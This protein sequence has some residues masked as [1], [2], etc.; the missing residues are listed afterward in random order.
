MTLDEFADLTRRVIAED[1]FDDYA[2][3]AVYP[4]RSFLQV[5]SGVPATEDIEKVALE[6]ATRDARNGE[7]FLVAFKVGS[8]QFKIIRRIGL[9]SE[10][11]VFKVG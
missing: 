2:P 8:D 1:G 7:E 10:D 5:L 11:E 6:W 3:T 9:Y 4:G